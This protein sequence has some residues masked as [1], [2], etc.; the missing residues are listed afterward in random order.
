VPGISW[1][2]RNRRPWWASLAWLLLWLISLIVFVVVARH[3]MLPFCLV[4]IGFAVLWGFWLSGVKQTLWVA[5][6]MIATA[7][8]AVGLDAPHRDGPA[9]ELSAL[10]LISAVF[11]IVVWRVRRRQSA[12]A[13]QARLSEEKGHLLATQRRFLQNTSHQLRTPITIALGHAELLAHD[14]AGRGGQRDIHVVVGELTRL[15]RLSERLLMIAVSE[16]PEFL[17][18]EQVALD[19][20]VSDVLGRWAPAAER[21]WRLGPTE[22]VTVHA[23]RERLAL[24]VDALLE[25]AVQHTAAGDV[26]SLSVLLDADAGNAGVVVEDTGEGIAAEELDTIFGRFQTGPGDS[27]SRGTGLGLALVR[28]ITRGHGGEVR[29]HSEQGTGSRFELM[30]PLTPAVPGDPAAVPSAQGSSGAAEG[31]G[32]GD[33]STP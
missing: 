27:G 33:R 5:S 23:D 25:N 3:A 11:L 26:I 19:G 24:A 16:D 31:A 29:V 30:L 12:H 2:P 15:K 7:V 9:E 10:G 28:A 1:L 8:A 22:A 20:F 6:T 18:P 14:L 21:Q 17:R 13:E 4:W 32:T